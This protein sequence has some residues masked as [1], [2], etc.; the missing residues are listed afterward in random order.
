MGET[1]TINKLKQTNAQNLC[2]TKVVNLEPFTLINSFVINLIS[3]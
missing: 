3:L 1:V 2:N